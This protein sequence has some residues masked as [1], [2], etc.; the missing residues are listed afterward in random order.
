MKKYTSE[1]VVK[2]KALKILIV[3]FLLLSACGKA[4]PPSPTAT[5]E[6]KPVGTESVAEVQPEADECVACHTDKERLIE[7]AAPE[8]EAESES[9]G[10]G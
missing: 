6:E 10:V 1:V 2:S 8:M 4:N 3:A 9:K 7:T 5:A